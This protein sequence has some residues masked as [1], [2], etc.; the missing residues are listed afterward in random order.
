MPNHSPE[1]VLEEM[2]DNIRRALAWTGALSVAELAADEKT[3]YAVIRCLE[4]ISEARRR[5]PDDLKQRHP[6]IPWRS[7]ADAGSFNRHV[8]HDLD[9]GII[10]ST[11]TQSLGPLAAVVDAELARARPST[12]E[13]P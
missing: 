5:L 6:S 10:W 11:V 12:G 7:M 13:T 4:I 1:V 3:F 2:H 8:Y 9:P